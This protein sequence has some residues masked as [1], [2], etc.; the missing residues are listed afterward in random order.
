M[1]LSR[2]ILEELLKINLLIIWNLSQRRSSEALKFVLK[3]TSLNEDFNWV[4]KHLISVGYSSTVPVYNSDSTINKSL[5]R[6]VEFRV[7]MDAQEQLFKILGGDLP[8]RIKNY[9][10]TNE[11]RQDELN[12][13][14]LK[15]MII[16][17]S[18][19]SKYEIT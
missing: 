8:K 13:I 14:R 15:K 11:E 17:W 3:E 9:R 4:K 12:K 16:N 10:L 18:S 5:S 6:R 7:V 1:H 19:G 2:I